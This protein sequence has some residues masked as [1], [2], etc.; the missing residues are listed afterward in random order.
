[1]ETR[2]AVYDGKNTAN[3]IG[4]QNRHLI[5]ALL[6]NHVIVLRDGGNI[7]RKLNEYLHRTDISKKR[8]AQSSTS[9]NDFVFE[10]SR[11]HTP[12]C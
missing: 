4:T 3:K 7:T 2:W 9:H 5:Y 12:A 8:T 11:I 1:M 6:G 10:R